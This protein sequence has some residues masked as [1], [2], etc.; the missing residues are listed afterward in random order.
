MTLRKSPL[1]PIRGSMNAFMRNLYRSINYAFYGQDHK[2]SHKSP[3]LRLPHN[4]GL[5]ASS[6]SSLSSALNQ[7][8][9]CLLGRLPGRWC[10][11]FPLRRLS[12]KKLSSTPLRAYLLESPRPLKTTRSLT[13][14]AKFTQNLSHTALSGK[15]EIPSLRHFIP[16]ATSTASEAQIE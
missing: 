12:P 15:G 8:H 2:Q 9:G 6:L 7:P 5:M 4:S 16:K 10:S 3:V 1:F 11:A 13:F 14:S